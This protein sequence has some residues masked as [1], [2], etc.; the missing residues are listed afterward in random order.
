MH[1]I[2]TVFMHIDN[3]IGR[4]IGVKSSSILDLACPGSLVYLDLEGT[5]MES[6]A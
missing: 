6:D 2:D 1:C 4:G 5:L 3:G